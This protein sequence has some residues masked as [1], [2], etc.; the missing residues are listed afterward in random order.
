MKLFL[1]FMLIYA[2]SNMN[3]E[4]AIAGKTDNPFFKNYDTPFEVPPFDKIKFEHFLPAVEEGIKQQQTEINA[5]V[6]N[7]ETPTFENTLEA[8]D[9]SGKLLSNVTSVLFNLLSANTSD[10]LQQIS[11][12]AS[13]LLSKNSDDIILNE[14][15]FARIKILYDQKDKLNLR[16]DQSKLLEDTYKR[17]TK[18]GV[19]LSEKDKEKLR[20]INSELSLLSLQFSENLLKETNAFKLVIDNEKDLDGLP[21]NV[22]TGAADEAKKNGM[23][24]KWVFTLQKPSLI[25]FITY[26]DNRE[27][28]EKIYK[29]YYNR[30]DNNNERDNKELIKKIVALRIEK[31][32]LL[33]YDTHAEYVLDDTMAKTPENV[34][35]LLNRLWDAALP[36]AKKEA[37]ELQK[38][39]YAEGNN[40]KLESWDWWY[41]TEKLKKAKYDLDEEEI[42]PYFQM[43]NVRKGAFDLAG[44]LWGIT[45]TELQR[46]P[47]YHPEVTVYEVKEKDGRHIGLLYTDYF[48]RDSKRGGAWMNSLRRQNKDVTPV[49]CNVGNFSK[50]AGDTPGLLSLDEVNTLFH[51]FGHGLHGLLSKTNYISQ[52][53]TSV[54]RD[55]VE[56]PSQVMENWVT[57]PEI[58]KTFAF[59]YKTGE[60]IPDDLIEKI[61]KTA[62]FNQGFITVEYLAASLL[63]MK[64]HTLKSVSDLDV[65]KFETEALNEIGL[66]PEII[67]R[68][69]STYFQHIFSSGYDAGYYSYIWAGVLDADA[70]EAFKETSLYDQKTAASFRENVLSKGGTED[71][72][73][74]YKN[75]RGKEPSIEPLLKRRGLVQEPTI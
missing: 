10:E 51:E 33:G 50:P 8:L 39:I 61:Q 41:Y 52:S 25:P 35:K 69:R 48:P 28:R 67:S 17:F 54:S 42:R 45:F 13:P 21:A 29:G 40:F 74:L 70:F 55:F 37:D 3:S 63:D 18:R 11:K 26:A 56:L 4:A 34:Y 16:R 71:P 9:N 72:M 58:L 57:E 22:I 24:G 23:E 12:D 2:F 65:N 46:I 64:Y 14:K 66:I 32:K 30:G 1:I 53:G 15:L 6:N 59:H 43:E 60:V 7:Q 36:M 19:N 31:A 75:F 5:I 49:I 47:T 44:K 73:V 27:L 62:H 68:Y 38:M 20:S